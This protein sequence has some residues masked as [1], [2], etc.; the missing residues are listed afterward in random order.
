[1]QI[2]AGFGN[3][4]KVSPTTCENTYCTVYCTLMPQTHQL[5]LSQKQGHN[6]VFKF[7]G[8]IPWSRVLIPF[9][10]KKLDRSTQ[11][12]AV[13]YII[14]LH[15]SNSYVKSWGVRPNFW[16]VRTPHPPV[17]APMHRSK[18]TSKNGI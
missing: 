15:S 3:R 9:Y 16:G 6:H 7:G 1:M 8:P 14:T 11:F 4:L 2:I 5:H 18:N 13:G 10:S 12:G 17:I